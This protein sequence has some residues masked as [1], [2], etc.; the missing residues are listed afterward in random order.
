MESVQMGSHDSGDGLESEFLAPV[1]RGPPDGP[2]PASTPR[3]V[4][5]GEMDVGFGATAVPG[6]GTILLGAQA[7]HAA[8]RVKS[9][10][11]HTPR[12][13]L[14]WAL[15]ASEGPCVTTGPEAPAGGPGTARRRS[16]RRLP[17]TPR[18]GRWT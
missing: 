17:L 4:L 14:R 2:L 9:F 6:S 1:P 18:R 12:E 3:D 11:S 5:T 16:Q 15:G 7:G 10:W 8:S 13:P